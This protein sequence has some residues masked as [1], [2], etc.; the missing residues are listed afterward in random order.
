MAK[1]ESMASEGEIRD[2]RTSGEDT[3]PEIL[4]RGKVQQGDGDSATN[5]QQ[6]SVLEAEG[7]KTNKVLVNPALRGDAGVPYTDEDGN[8]KLEIFEAGKVHYVDDATRA[9]KFNGVSMFVDAP[10][11]SE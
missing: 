7:D 11:D 9:L 4:G 6:V 8:A 1:K 3:T 10:E 5:Q 2:V